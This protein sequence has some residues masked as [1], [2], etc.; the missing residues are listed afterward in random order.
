[1]LLTS[2]GKNVNFIVRVLL[3]LLLVDMMMELADV[4]RNGGV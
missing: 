1:M 2:S 3:L 4:Q